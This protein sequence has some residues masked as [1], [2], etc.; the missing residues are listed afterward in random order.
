MQSLKEAIQQKKIDSSIAKSER[1]E[2]LKQIYGY[3]EKDY[4]RQTWISY[5]QWLKDNR[6]KHTRDTVE[7]YKKIA[8][9][10]IIISS[11]CSYWL[12]P[13]P[14]KDLYYILSNAKSME[15]RGESF[16]KWLFHSLKV[17]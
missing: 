10:Q 9:K 8:Y 17:A 15:H 3:Y 7:M 6:K 5:I 12:S 16:N 14:T 11:F 2:I 4:K 1:A 13:I